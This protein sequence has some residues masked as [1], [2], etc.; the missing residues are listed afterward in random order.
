MLRIAQH[1]WR[2]ALLIRAHLAGV[3][4]GPGSAEQREE[5]YTASGT[6]EE[7]CDGP[8]SRARTD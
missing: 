8:K 5:R 3:E 2:G 7:R 6:R 1:L 4:M